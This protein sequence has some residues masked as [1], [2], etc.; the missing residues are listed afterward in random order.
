MCFGMKLPLLH[1]YIFA[2]FM[3]EMEY[4]RN[5]CYNDIL[6]KCIQCRN[7]WKLKRHLLR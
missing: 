7:S 1:E 2:S 4:C 6:G 5:S 3:N